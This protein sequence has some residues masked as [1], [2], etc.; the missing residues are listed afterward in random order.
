MS[1]PVPAA[2]HRFHIELRLVTERTREAEYKTFAGIASK[3]PSPFKGLPFVIHWGGATVEG[4]TDDEGTVVADVPGTATSGRLELRDPKDDPAS[5]ARII[6]PLGSFSPS[7]GMTAPA[8]DP[9]RAEA[10]RG[11][12]RY[13][14]KNLGL[15]ESDS[16]AAFADALRRYLFQRRFIGSP[17]VRANTER[18]FPQWDQADIVANDEEKLALILRE[19]RTLH[20]RTRGL[21]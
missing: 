20:D 3:S 8:G 15:L 4:T 6:I 11:E 12:I 7:A 5:P 17:T 19:L 14:L 21:T 9:E 13:R 10:L 2:P 18:V 1:D 16:A